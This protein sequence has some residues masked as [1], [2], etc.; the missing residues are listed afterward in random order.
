MVVEVG[1]SISKQECDSMNEILEK[2]E[3]LTQE[4]KEVI[5]S[6]LEACL[7]DQKQEPFADH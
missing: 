1:S 3:Q 7:S 5:F 2:F 4:E 6:F